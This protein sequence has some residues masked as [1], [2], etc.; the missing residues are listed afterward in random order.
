LAGVANRVILGAKR[1]SLERCYAGPWLPEPL[2][3]PDAGQ[4]ELVAEQASWTPD[5]G[6]RM[7]AACKVIRG[8]DRVVRFVLG[9]LTGDF[10]S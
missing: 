6:G 1:A 3:D 2:R 9:V 4:G 5:G 8:R 10:G 7:Q